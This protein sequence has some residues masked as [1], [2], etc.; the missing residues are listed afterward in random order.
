METVIAQVQEVLSKSKKKLA[1]YLYIQY[2]QNVLNE[3]LSFKGIYV[4]L[5]VIY[6]Y[7]FYF[8]EKASYQ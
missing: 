7:L 4:N 5:R 6:M 8:V 3:I 2:V 1:L